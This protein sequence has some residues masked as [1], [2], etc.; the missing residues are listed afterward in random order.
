MKELHLSEEDS[1]DDPRDSDDNND[2]GGLDET[3]QYVPDQGGEEA[4][5]SGSKPD[6]PTADPP[7]IPDRSGNPNGSNPGDPVGNAPPGKPTTSKGKGPNDESSGKAPAPKVQLSAAALGVQDRARS[8][9]FNAAT[10]AQAVGSEEDTVRRL[11]NYT[12]LLTGLQ[13]LVG[14]MASG[15]EAATEDI[16]SLVASMLNQATLRDRNFVAESSQAL[17]DLTVKYQQAMS[18]GGSLQEQLASWD[19]V[20]EAGIALSRKI[21][22]LISEEGSTASGEIF[23]TLLPACFQH[24]C[25]RTEATFAELNAN[26]PSL[27]CRFVTPDQAGHILASIFTC[28]CNYNTEICGMAMAQTVV[29]VYTIP[30]TYRVQQSLWESMC[31]IIPGIARTGASAPRSAVSAAT[32]NTAM[33]QPSTVPDAGRSGSRGTGTTGQ[34]GPQGVKAS[35]THRTASEGARPL[36]IL[37]AGSKWVVFHNW[38]P[39]YDLTGDGEPTDI[40]PLVTSTPIKAAQVPERRFSGNKLNACKIQASHLIFDMQDRQEKAWRDIEA[41]NQAAIHDR[42]SSNDPGSGGKRPHG[43]PVSLPNL[44]GAVQPTG[45]SGG[46]PAS[47]P[48]GTK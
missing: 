25:V 12:G 40:T 21:T 15:Y 43:L 34:S 37:P 9:L 19:Q 20:R 41:G 4:E 30:N 16:R 45:A 35:S 10:L 23:K 5:A 46:T 22:A 3:K 17:A 6:N 18:Q 31:W 36:G 42:T 39:T 32:G 38:A 24:I 44:V 27:L 1:D 14:T 13:K 47:S 29:P 7:T 11:E 26:L 8:T 48:H 28:L 33:G 2:G